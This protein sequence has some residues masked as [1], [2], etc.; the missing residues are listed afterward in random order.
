[1]PQRKPTIAM[2]VANIQC[3]IWV[4]RSFITVMT[5]EA[6]PTLLPIPR[7]RSIKKNS[8]AKACGS[9]LNFA[10]ASGY[11]IKAKPAPPFTTLAISEVFVSYAKFP[12]MPNIM[13][14]AK[15]DV[16]ESTLVIIMTSLEVREQK[17]FSST[18]VYGI[19]KQVHVMYPMAP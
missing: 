10:I 15:I 4:K 7:T 19:H 9:S 13:Q 11:E 2:T 6:M 17:T 5:H 3:D 14:P 1:M 12:R 16:T 8:T 18:F